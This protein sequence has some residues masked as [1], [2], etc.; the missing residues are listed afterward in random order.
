ML[1]T[2]VLLRYGAMRTLHKSRLA[3]PGVVDGKHLYNATSGRLRTFATDVSGAPALKVPL[4]VHK[5]HFVPSEPVD[6]PANLDGMLQLARAVSPGGGV[7]GAL[8]ELFRDW[9]AYVRN[10]TCLK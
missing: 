5:L 10:D 7:G 9:R 1:L 2:Q 8:R 4:E 3:A 6:S